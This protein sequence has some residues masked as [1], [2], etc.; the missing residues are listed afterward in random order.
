MNRRAFSRLIGTLITILVFVSCATTSQKKT[1]QGISYIEKKKIPSRIAI[2][3]PV[4]LPISQQNTS[5]PVD[6]K[7]KKAKFI[8]SLVRKSLY[9]HLVGKGYSVMNLSEADKKLSALGVSLNSISPDQIK[10]VCKSLN[11]DGI[12]L[13]KID[14]ASM[15]SVLAFNIFQ[16]NAEVKM[17][18]KDGKELG[19]WSEKVSQK[20]LSVPLSPLGAVTTVA[21][22]VFIEPSSKMQMRMVIYEWA[23][24]I[25]QLIPD[26]PYGTKLP[27]IV[28]VETNID[29]GLFKMGDKISVKVSAEKDLTCFFDIGEFKKNIPMNSNGRGEYSGFYIVKEGDY[30]VKQ[31]LLIHLI[32]P[33]G[34]ER[35]WVESEGAISIDGIPPKP[36]E[37]I[38]AEVSK[39]GVQIRWKIADTRDIKGFLIERADKPLGKAS[40]VARTEDVRFIDT[41]VSQGRT[42]YYRIMSI[43]KAGNL[44][45][46]RLIS[47]TVP[48]FKQIRLSQNL[49]GNLIAGTYILEKNAIVP[50]GEI[51]RIGS[52]VKIKVSSGVGILVKGKIEIEGSATEPAV[53]TGK[54]WKGI[55]IDSGRLLAENFIL[56]GCNSCIRA[57]NGYVRISKGTVKQGNEKGCGISTM[58]DA[59]VDL[60]DVE[61]MGFER[62]ILLYGGRGRI[63]RCTIRDNKIGIELK[64]GS[65]ELLNNNIFDNKEKDII[66]HQRIVL[67]DNYLGASLPSKLRIEGNIIVKSLFDAPFP[68]GRRIVLIGNREISAKELQE[69]FKYYKT[70]GKKAFSER[71]YG[72]AYEYFKKA[73]EIKKD[74]DV[75]LYL[76]YTKMAMGETEGIDSLFKEAIEAFPYEV[77]LY[78]VYVRYLIS[79]GEKE[80]AM[81]MLQKAI[82]MNP[83]DK[84]LIFMMDV[85]RRE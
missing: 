26:N 28:S 69:K 45:E 46:S 52:G 59:I 47:V 5:W 61:I 77:R 68:E 50:E 16:I 43:D 29:K 67:S 12:V 58:E 80:K 2:L 39:D 53:I 14:A 31:P 48:F 3:R 40:F 78:Q 42:Y 81:A 73:I 63:Y 22:A 35:V 51:L 64:D 21:S 4:M 38:K 34:T 74:R 79:K 8:K 41:K 82:R 70:M 20:K 37:D 65:F 57:N 71:R 11:L 9:N 27:K 13:I 66:S 7:S 18:D 25:S 56:D 44:S 33:N 30:A 6:P 75:Y 17:F 24:R 76:I 23:W 84:S 15:T 32:R 10:H 85:L 1:A 19:S 60:S 83:E 54:D 72:D 55:E 36:P 62:G 49:R